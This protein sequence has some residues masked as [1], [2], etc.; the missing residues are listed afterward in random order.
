LLTQIRAVIAER[1]FHG[2]GHRQIWVRLRAL[3]GVR[4]SMRRVLRV[5]RGAEL[6]APAR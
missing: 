6:L 3:K 4:T 1:P 5:M 2:E